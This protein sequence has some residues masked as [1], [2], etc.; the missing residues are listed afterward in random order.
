MGPK[1]RNG[2]SLHQ[3]IWTGSGADLA[4]CSTIAI[5]PVGGWW[6][7][8]KRKDRRE[9]P[10]RYSL[11]VSLATQATAVD[12]YEPIATQLAIDVGAVAIEV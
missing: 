11:L 12:I 2:G 6:K 9:F 1:T 10:V 3:Y 7:N 8:G 5:H 4:Q